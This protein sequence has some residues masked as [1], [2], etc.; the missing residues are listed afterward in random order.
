MLAVQPGLDSRRRSVQTAVRAVKLTPP[1][2]TQ[3]HLEGVCSTAAAHSPTPSTKR[4]R[5]LSENKVPE[6][7]PHTP[8]QHALLKSTMQPRAPPHST[9][10]LLVNTCVKLS[11]T[12]S[13]T[14]SVNTRQPVYQ[15]RCAVDRPH[16]Q[17]E[18]TARQWKYPFVTNHNHRQAGP[19]S[20]LA[21]DGRRQASGS[22]CKWK[23][24]S[25]VNSPD[26]TVGQGADT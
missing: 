15:T 9:P 14:P 17:P 6:S 4:G 19:A 10:Q 8:A 11:A 7:N 26:G 18:K 20:S 25:A 21:Q 16:V 2:H 13:V 22:S 3:P 12:P 5:A 24:Q 1:P 23:P